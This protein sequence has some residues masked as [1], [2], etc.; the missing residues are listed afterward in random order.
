M[1]MKSRPLVLSIDEYAPVGYDADEERR[2]GL[3]V[4]QPDYINPASS[5]LCEF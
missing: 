1:S 5:D 2:L 4:L 3:G